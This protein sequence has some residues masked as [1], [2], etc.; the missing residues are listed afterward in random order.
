MSYYKLQH[1]PKSFD[2]SKNDG[3]ENSIDKQQR[4]C[5]KNVI[6]K[7]A[8]CKYNVFINVQCP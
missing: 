6:S 5:I 1:K 4:F 7:F 8:Y 3:Y 2:K